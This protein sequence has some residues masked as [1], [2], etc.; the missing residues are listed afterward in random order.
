MATGWTSELR[1]RLILSRHALHAAVLEIPWQGPAIRWEADLS[2]EMVEFLDG[3]AIS[4]V[5]EIVIW[6]RD[7]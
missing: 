7:D 1:E 6:N 4:S 5:P 3:K 2:R